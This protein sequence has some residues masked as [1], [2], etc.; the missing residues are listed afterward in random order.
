MF[1]RYTETARKVIFALNHMARE[2]GSTEIGSEHLLVVLLCAD[3]VL[4][5]RFLRGGGQAVKQVD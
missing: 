2:V 1:E 5:R 4:A 3:K